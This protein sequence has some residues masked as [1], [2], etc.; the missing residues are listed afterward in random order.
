MN[1]DKWVGGQA[2]RPTMSLQWTLEIR[3]LGSRGGPERG[4]EHEHHKL[5]KNTQKGCITF[6]TNADEHRASAVKE[7]VVLETPLLPSHLQVERERGQEMGRGGGGLG[8]ERIPYSGGRSGPI[9]E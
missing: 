7:G 6:A 8:E 9:A 4:G 3:T 2:D 5:M 1:E